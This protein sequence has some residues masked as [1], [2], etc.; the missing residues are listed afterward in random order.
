MKFQES[1]FISMQEA[2]EVILQWLA[3]DEFKQQLKC[4]DHLSTDFKQGA[5][6]GAA[7]AALQINTKPKK[8]LM[9]CEAEDATVG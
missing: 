7:M 9:P 3:S 2:G 6:W 8:Y 1:Y 5:M 4:C